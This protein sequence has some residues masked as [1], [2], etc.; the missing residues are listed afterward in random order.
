M[1]MQRVHF[2]RSGKV[3][4]LTLDDG[5]ANVFSPE[6]IAAINAHLDDVEARGGALVITARG[7]RF[8]GGFDLGVLQGDDRAAAR[9]LLDTGRDLLLRLFAFPRPV[10]IGCN[11]HAMALGAFVLLCG[12]MRVAVCGDYRVALPEVRI[13]MSVPFWALEV[14]RARL[15]PRYFSRAATLAETF[16][17]DRL[18]EAGFADEVVAPDALMQR[19]LAIAGDLA[20]LNDPYFADT[21]RRERGPVIEQVR[22][23]TERERERVRAGDA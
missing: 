17:P 11:G 2:E 4:S 18:L 7:P 13:G 8:S 19:C 23:L 12:D 9:A 21:K 20:E 22:E 6:T 10:V 15:S 14:A 1:T 5:K 3:A 16:G